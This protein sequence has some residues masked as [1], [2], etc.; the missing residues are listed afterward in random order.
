MADLSNLIA[1]H[2]NNPH[3]RQVLNGWRMERLELGE[4]AEKYFDDDVARHATKCMT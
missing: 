3:M 2:T 1:S 4:V